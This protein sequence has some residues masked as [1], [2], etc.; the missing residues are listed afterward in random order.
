MKLKKL[1]KKNT[2]SLKKN[3]TQNLK[4]SKSTKRKSTKRKS[5]RRKLNTINRNKSK[6]KG[7]ANRTEPIDLDSLRFSKDD[8]EIKITLITET[9]D[10]EMVVR[11]PN[12]NVLEAISREL[13]M[14]DIKVM[15]MDN[16]LTID[17]D[18]TFRSHGIEDGATLMVLLNQKNLIVLVRSNCFSSGA[19]CEYLVDDSHEIEQTLRDKMDIPNNI[20]IEIL[21]DNEE[22]IKEHSTFADYTNYIKE[23]DDFIAP[24]NREMFINVTTLDDWSCV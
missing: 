22:P 21:I 1:S 3:L 19:R 13:E 7:G 10:R 15:W 18:D 23:F 11:N 12:D 8:D 5:T 17:E 24:I 6:R 9:G 14:I 16:E 20:P 2:K 4:T